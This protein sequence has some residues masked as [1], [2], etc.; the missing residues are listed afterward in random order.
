MRHVHIT[1]RRLQPYDLPMF[2]PILLRLS[3]RLERGALLMRRQWHKRHP[4]IAACH[5]GYTQINIKMQPNPLCLPHDPLPAYRSAPPSS[6]LRRLCRRRRRN[7]NNNQSLCPLFHTSNSRTLPIMLPYLLRSLHTPN[8]VDNGLCSNWI[9]LHYCLP[10]WSNGR[11][12]FR[13]ISSNSC[14]SVLQ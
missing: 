13:S 5:S 8:S 11:L 7:C 10:C 6:I 14:F 1:D 3:S 9:L 12:S 4:S 2:P